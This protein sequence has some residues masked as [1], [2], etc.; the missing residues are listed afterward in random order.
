MTTYK[1]ANKKKGMVE[2][3]YV[4]AK[5]NFKTG[6]VTLMYKVPGGKA[7]AEKIAEALHKAILRAGKIDGTFRNVLARL[8]KVKTLA[9]WRPDADWWSNASGPG[10]EMV[11]MVYV[12]QPAVKGFGVEDLAV[13]LNEPA[14]VPS[15]PVTAEAVS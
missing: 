6:K 3:G 12:N 9:A 15:E 5:W 2:Y 10:D 1:I 11:K 13:D 14:A 7:V 4:G 8:L